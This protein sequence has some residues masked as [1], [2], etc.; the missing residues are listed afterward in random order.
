L[1]RHL[2]E[3]GFNRSSEHHELNSWFAETVAAKVDPRIA[4]VQAWQRATSE[5]PLFVLEVPWLRT[6]L[7]LREVADR[8]ARVHG[9]AG[10]RITCADDIVRL[11]IN[12]KPRRERTR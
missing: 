7:S 10:P 6:G 8:I 1:L 12:T 5:D 4:S 3:A 2:L 9:R 11:V